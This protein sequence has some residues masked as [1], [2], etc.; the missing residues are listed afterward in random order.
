MVAVALSLVIYYDPLNPLIPNQ[1]YDSKLGLFLKQC[2]SMTDTYLPWIHPK[3]LIYAKTKTLVDSFRTY[4]NTVVKDDF[5]EPKEEFKESEVKN[6]NRDDFVERLAADQIRLVELKDQVTKLL[7]TKYEKTPLLKKDNDQLDRTPTGTVSSDLRQGDLLHMGTIDKILDFTFEFLR[8]VTTGYVT[9]KTA[10]L[11]RTAWKR[12]RDNLMYLQMLKG[13]YGE[14]V[15][16]IILL[17]ELMLWNTKDHNGV[18]RSF[19]LVILKVIQ[20]L[21]TV[22]QKNKYRELWETVSCT[23]SVLKKEKA[24]LMFLS[25]GQSTTFFSNID[26]LIQTQQEN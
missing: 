10:Y 20:S 3:A 22:A 13:F 12:H 14:T 25:A 6:K 26:L 15:E 8:E 17:I 9:L 7:E 5:D 1:D 21:A 11:A 2:Q 18:E 4:I 23:F 19:S 16:L 24:M